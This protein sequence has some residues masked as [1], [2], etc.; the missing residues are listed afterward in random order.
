[1]TPQGAFYLYADCSRFTRD[2]H[3]FAS[4]LLDQAGVAVTPGIDFGQHHAARH[5]RFAYTQPLPRLAEALARLDRF[6]RA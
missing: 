4:Q 2:S 5:V 6:L 1:V 3:A